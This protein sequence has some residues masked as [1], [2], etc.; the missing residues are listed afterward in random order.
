[1]PLTPPI[2]CCIVNTTL[3]NAFQLIV[4]YYLAEPVRF[5]S[6]RFFGFELTPKMQ[7]SIN[8]GT[9]KPFGFL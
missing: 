2:L 6:P 5:F 3:I 4:K 8:L 7:N 9:S 1:M